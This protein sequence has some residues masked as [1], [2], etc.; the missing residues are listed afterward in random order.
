MG[1]RKAALQAAYAAHTVSLPMFPEVEERRQAQVIEAVRQALS[2]PA[3]RL[4]GAAW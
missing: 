2:W 3:G 1:M 4:Y